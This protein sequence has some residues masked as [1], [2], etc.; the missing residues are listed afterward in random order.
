MN[1]CPFTKA[2]RE[3]RQGCKGHSSSSPLALSTSFSFVLSATSDIPAAN[4]CSLNIVFARLHR[5]TLRSPQVEGWVRKANIHSPLLT[6]GRNQPKEHWNRH[7]RAMAVAP[8]CWRL[9]SIGTQLSDLGFEIW[10]VLHRARG[11]TQ[12]FLWA[13]SRWEHSNSVI[14]SSF[15]LP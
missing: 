9:R 10:M 13:F 8:S 4:Q 7:Q 5:Q 15:I 12:W 3:G 11:W 14:L 2:G 6:E 1:C